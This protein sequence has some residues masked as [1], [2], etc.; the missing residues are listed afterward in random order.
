MGRQGALRS[1]VGT[2]APEYRVVQSA[3]KAVHTRAFPVEEGADLPGFFSYRS[4][5]FLVEVYSDHLHNN[6]RTHLERGTANDTLWQ[7]LWKWMAS[8]SSSF[9]PETRFPLSGDPM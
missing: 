7:H 2:Q 5:I 6:D 4:H 3:H 9:H 1:K 8:Q